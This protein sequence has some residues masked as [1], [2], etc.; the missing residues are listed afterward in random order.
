MPSKPP[1]CRSSRRI[2]TGVAET[3][4]VSYMYS[5][6]LVLASLPDRERVFP[7][8]GQVQARVISDGVGPRQI[9]TVHAEVLQHT[10]KRKWADAPAAT[11][12]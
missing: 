2:T 7:D 12:H 9:L 4:V 6:L 11:V 5:Q 3:C 8:L 1:G 10:N